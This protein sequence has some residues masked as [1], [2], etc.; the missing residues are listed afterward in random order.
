M[1]REAALRRLRV[2]E[3]EGAFRLRFRAAQEHEVVRIPHQLQTGRLAGHVQRMQMHVREE[4]ADHPSLRR[5]FVRRFV[6]ARLHHARAQ[7]PFDEF[8]HPSVADLA[9]HFG[10]E[11]RMGD[12]VEAASEVRLHDPRH[13]VLQAAFDDAQRVLRPDL[14][15]EAVARG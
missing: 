8:Q 4:R 12:R 3:R 15:A 1:Q 10:Q 2:H 14:R 11:P 9:P 5:A 7:H 6:P 13:A